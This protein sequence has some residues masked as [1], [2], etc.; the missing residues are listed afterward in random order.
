MDGL[1]TFIC[2]FSCVAALHEHGRRS[3]DK[4]SLVLPGSAT[5][6][7]CSLKTATSLRQSEQCGTTPTK[8]MVLRRTLQWMGHVLRMYE[9]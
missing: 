2:P 6:S 8:L 7:A 1:R 9:D 3:A 5:L 4:R